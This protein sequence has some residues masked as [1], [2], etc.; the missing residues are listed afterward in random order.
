MK[1]VIPFILF[2]IITSVIIF[3]CKNATETQKENISEA[4]IV[5]IQ[6]KI[7]EESIEDMQIAL[8]SAMR[9]FH[10]YSQS[11]LGYTHEIINPSKNVQ[12][13][14][15][16][17][18][19]SLN[20]GV[21]L[22]DLTYIILND[23]SMYSNQYIKALKEL[24][25]GIGM[26]NVIDAIVIERFEGNLHNKD[27]LLDII[28]LVK[29]DMDLFFTES[30]ENYK[31][32]IFF[33]GTLVEG[34]YISLN[35]NIA[36]NEML[37]AAVMQQLDIVEQIVPIMENYPVKSKSIQRLTSYLVQLNDL[38]QNSIPDVLDEVAPVMS[39]EMIIL[40]SDQIEILRTEIINGNF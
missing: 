28:S 9:V 3:S 40:L 2:L 26:T 1:K 37:Q 17:L 23:K 20:T 6:T 35:S 33:I 29:Q 15:T 38:Y 13:Y 7:V 10:N 25:E 18:A 27:S 4:T 36:E 19:K 21:F 8:P 12:K 32:N 24:T 14:Q 30:G 31:K 39:S 34:V 11:G 16:N 5:K 22:A